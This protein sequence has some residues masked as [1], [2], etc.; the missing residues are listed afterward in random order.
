MRDTYDFDT[1]PM[2]EK[3]ESVGVNYDSTKARKEASSL[4]SQLI[5]TVGDNP[6]GSRLK[7]QSNPHEFGC[8]YSVAFVFD[9][10]NEEHIQ[11]LNK[12]EENF[13][14]F[15]DEQSKKELSA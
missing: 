5:R 14:E 6:E 1:V 15:W 4:I 2:S 8:Y 7:V 12:L 9:N 11:H 10:E 13:P 3:C